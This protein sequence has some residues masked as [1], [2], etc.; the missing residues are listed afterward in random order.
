MVTGH[1]SNCY[2]A[3][4]GHCCLRATANND[5]F[6]AHSRLPTMAL[7][8]MSCASR[9]GSTMS[10]ASVLQPLDNPPRSSSDVK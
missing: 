4:I 3:V 7:R 10:C 8:T 6:S 1:Q 5:A 2:A 9:S